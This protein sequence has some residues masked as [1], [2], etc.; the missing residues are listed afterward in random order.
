MCSKSKCCFE[1]CCVVLCCHVSAGRK[2]GLL[3]VSPECEGC[4][5]LFGVVLCGSVTA[6]R[7]RGLV[8]GGSECIQRVSVVLSCTVLC[9]VV[10]Q[11]QAERQALCFKSA[12]WNPPVSFCCYPLACMPDIVAPLCISCREACIHDMFVYYLWPF[13]WQKLLK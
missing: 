3:H 9:C 6:G 5:E 2:T 1:L 10:V 4:F 11:L 13:D 7:K 12:V 8:R